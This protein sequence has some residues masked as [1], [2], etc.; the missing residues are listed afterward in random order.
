VAKI[1]FAWELGGN[2]GHL[3]RD[4]PI[5]EALRAQ[6]HHVAFAVRDLAT[7]A[8]LLIPKG[9]GF[10]QA[11]M[12]AH[13]R[14]ET[15]APASF[16][17]ILLADGW[18]QPSALLG[19]LKAWSMLFDMSRPDLVVADHAPT[20]LAAA[21]CASVPAIPFG[22]GFEIPPPL[23]PSPSIR[24]WETISDERLKHAEEVVLETL[25]QV[26]KPLGGAGVG[27][28]SDLFENAVLTTY[29]ELDHYGPRSAGQYVGA[30]HTAGGLPIV[31]WPKGGGPRVLAYLRPSVPGF[32]EAIQVLSDFEGV[33]ITAAPG[34]SK[35]EANRLSSERHRIVPY[36]I[37]I[38]SLLQQ[39]DAVV[40]YAG[41]GLITQSLLAGKPLLLMPQTVEQ[42]LGAQCV[43]V[44]GAG[45]VL[46]KER[47]VSDIRTMLACVLA[48]KDISAS[49]SRFSARYQADSPQISIGRACDA[50]LQ[51]VSTGSSSVLHATPIP[52]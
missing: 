47:S 11:P 18:G 27:Q 15:Q 2:L 37:R 45:R 7:A 52:K 10:V 51:F 16:A 13:G 36:P 30:W 41:V 46:E 39:T 3:G 26:A 33:A 12:F 24:P 50:I 38:E 4:L 31:E 9:F 17:E 44:L 35:S 48:D 40:S 34:L 43:Q 49:G 6:G 25:A 22:S 19:R 1:I 32:S 14:T 21:K 8:E 23:F 29:P 20:A 42:R 5:A 28:V